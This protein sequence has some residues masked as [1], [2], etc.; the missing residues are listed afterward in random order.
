MTAAFALFRQLILRPLSSEPLRTSLT[1]VSVAL[2]VAVVVAIRLAGD[3]AAGSFRSSMETLQGNASIEIRAAGGLDQNWLGK[4]V[5]LPYPLRFTPRIEAYARLA[6]NGRTVALFGIDLIAES[7]ETGML[8]FGDPGAFSQTIVCSEALKCRKDAPLRIIVNDRE[9]TYTVRGSV[10]GED[11]FL[12]LDIGEAQAATGRKGLLDRIEVQVPHESSDDWSGILRHALPESVEISPA[13]ADTEANR[14]MLTAFRWNLRVLSY[15]AMVVGAF[16]IYNSIAVSVVRRRTEIG[17]LRAVG[18]TDKQVMGLFLAEAVMFGALGSF[19]GLPAGRL[20]AEGAVKTLGATVQALYVSSAPGE[21]QLTPWIWLE[22]LLVGIGMSVLAAWIPAKEAARV[23]PVEAMARGRREHQFRVRTSRNLGFSIVAAVIAWVA[24]LQGSVYGRPLFGYLAAF[25]LIIATALAIPA[26]VQ[27]LAPAISFAA[28]RI[29][30]IEAMLAARSVRGSLLRSSILTAALAT[31]VAMMVSVGIMVGSFRETL[32]EW[33]GNQLRADLYIRPASAGGAGV[34]PTLAPGVPELLKQVPSVE[35]VERLRL[36]EIRFR[37][38][39]VQFGGAD[40]TVLRRH[41]RLQF[42]RGDREQILGRLLEG[43]Y[44]V[45]SEPLSNKYGVRVGDRLALAV[46]GGTITLEVAGVYHDYASERG[47]ILTDRA[48]LLRALPDPA[49]TNVALYM[50]PGDLAAARAEVERALAGHEVFISTNR[51][52]REEGLQV[53]DRTFAITW[54]LEAVAILIAVLGVAGALMAMVIDRRR[55]L[56][57]LRF[58]GA[59]RV[60]IKRLILCEAGILGLLGT[61]LG[62]FLGSLLSLLLIYVINEQSFG[63]TI[64]FHWPV[65][66]L[67]SALTGIWVATI[68]AGLWPV[69]AALRLKPIEVIHE[70]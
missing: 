54:A 36:Y 43:D 53:F 34:L 19:L 3:A 68:L 50:K 8:G 42:L 28:G 21:I 45:V 14:K 64:Q 62:F 31:A 6:E 51:S 57:L 66:L 65:V 47:T 7:L 38:I 1:V 35:A 17:V 12:I 5:Q 48:T 20:L 9:R 37:G 15:I 23:A 39:P 11:P 56:G 49:V 24:S 29:L 25:S 44:C 2:G 52:L 60:Q 69:R 40:M 13:G 4:L 22:A 58:L 32:A 27:A 30:G 16:L 63:W 33:M 26:L 41:G 59:S 55:E 70:E 67:F 10:P 46:G 18:A 61:L